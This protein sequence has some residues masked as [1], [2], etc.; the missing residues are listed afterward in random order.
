M[1]KFAD[2]SEVLEH[3]YNITLRYNSEYGNPPP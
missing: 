3:I 1:W 2:V